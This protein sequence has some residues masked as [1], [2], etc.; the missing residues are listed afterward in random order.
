MYLVEIWRTADDCSIVEYSPDLE[1]GSDDRYEVFLACPFCRENGEL[2]D[3]FGQLGE[4]WENM[5]QEFGKVF[6]ENS[7]V[8]SMAQWIGKS[9]SMLKSLLFG[10]GIS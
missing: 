9:V 2:I 6:S 8:R 3:E 4:A 10:G 5:M 7:F 1:M